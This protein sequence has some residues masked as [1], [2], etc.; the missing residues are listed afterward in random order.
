MNRT[1]MLSLDQKYYKDIELEISNDCNEK[2]RVDQTGEALSIWVDVLF[3]IEG[4]GRAIYNAA[5]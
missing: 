4:A 2:D 3:R 1:K 5:N